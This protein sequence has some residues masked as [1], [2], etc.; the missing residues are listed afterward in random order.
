A[1]RRAG[2]RRGRACGKPRESRTMSAAHATTATAVPSVVRPLVKPGTWLVIGLVFVALTAVGL[3][4]DTRGHVG[5]S[6]LISFC[7]KLVFTLGSMIMIMYHHVF[8]TCWSTV[9]RRL[10]VHMLAAFVPL[11]VLFSPLAIAGAYLELGIIWRWLDVSNPAVA[12][13]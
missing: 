4:V 2:S 6:W 11:A 5:F 12:G 13:N 7:F 3:V 10:M 1:A 8:N 9:P